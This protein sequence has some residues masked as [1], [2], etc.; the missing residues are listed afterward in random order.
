M[1]FG[2]VVLSSARFTCRAEF[3]LRCPINE[4]KSRYEQASKSKSKYPVKV[5]LYNV[6]P[7]SQRL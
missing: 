1:L 2:C 4:P 7:L 3:I 5:M 6:N